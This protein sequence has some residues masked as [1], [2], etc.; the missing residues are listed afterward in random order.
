METLVAAALG[1]GL[2]AAAGLRVFIPLL[3][4]NLASRF[5][6]VDLASGLEWV[7]STGALLAFAVAAVLEVVSYLVPLVDNLLDTIAT[8]AAAVAGTVMMGAVLVDVGPFWTWALAII[9]GGGTAA[10]VQ[11]TTVAVRATSTATTAGAANPIVGASESAG[12]FGLSVMSIAVPLLAAVMV[13][14]AIAYV[15]WKVP[16]LVGRVFRRDRSVEGSKS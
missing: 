1:V 12:S 6:F 14:A 5:E 8:P 4:L 15:L 13:V 7:G 9:A 11:G 2:A 3:V 10:I 16:R